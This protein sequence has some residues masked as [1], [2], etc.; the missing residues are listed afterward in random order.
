MWHIDSDTSADTDP[1]RTSE[2]S[3][4]AA[5]L[6]EFLDADRVG[7]ATTVSGIDALDAADDDDLAFCKYDDSDA[8]ADSDAGIVICLPGTVPSDGQ[9]V[10]HAQRPRAAF[11]RSV[12]EFFGDDG[13]ET[14]IHPSAIV[15]SGATVGEGCRIGAGAYV[16]SCVTLGD[17][18]TVGHGTVL[19]SPGFGFARLEDDEL[20]RQRHEG[21]VVLDDDVE[22]GA[23]CSIDRAVFEETHVGRGTKLSGN[24]HLAHQVELG[25]DVTVAFGSGFAG[26][27]RVGDRTTVHPHVTVATDV[28]VGDDAELGMN[29][30][31]LDDVPPN[32]TV[33]GSPAT[34]IEDHR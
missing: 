1:S 20:V 25:E 31:V 3:V 19:G 26:G 9:T 30:A 24:V 28:T 34:S 5:T 21:A 8:V 33:V 18:C 14:R 22:V 10:V 23:N 6:A 13:E 17:R 15:E 7:P 12:D 2:Q 32:T 27:V 16:A 4:D 11:I 29:A